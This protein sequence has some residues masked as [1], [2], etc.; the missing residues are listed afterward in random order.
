MFDKQWA[1]VTAGSM[2]HYN[3]CIYCFKGSLGIFGGTAG[4]QTNGLQFYVH[5]ARYTSEFLKNSD[6]FT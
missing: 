6:T 3:S 2:E 1:V 4:K 5:P